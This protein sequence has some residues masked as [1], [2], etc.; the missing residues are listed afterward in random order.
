MNNITSNLRI[1]YTPDSDDVFNYYGWESGHLE[2]PDKN[3]K[4]TFERNHI[5]ALNIAAQKQA[6]DVVG[7]SSVVYPLLEKDYWIM[8]VGNS[9]GRKYGPVLVSKNYH[10]LE[11]LEGKRIAIAGMPTTGG[12]LALMYCQGAELIA[13]QYD[14]ISDKIAQGE[15][16]AGV[17]IHEELLFFGE[18]GLTKV[19]DLGEAWSK[20]TGLPLPVGL[21]L[22]KK[23]LGRELA[24]QITKLCQ[25]SL[26]W[27]HDH[28]DEA[29]EA[30]SKVGRG[31]AEDHIRMFSND[32]TMN[33]KDDVRA[34]IKIMFDRMADLNVGPRLASY[35]IIETE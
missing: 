20:E 16:D 34:A 35:E 25:Q 15:Y 10:T 29:F 8:A 31:F 7:V 33:L 5:I 22:V 27:S 32:D 23:T 24:R 26:Q 18:K 19:C 17:M 30:A 28:Y 2:L 12:V 11:E 13:E 3:I 6:Y 9:V 21:N 1:A 4:V 14:L